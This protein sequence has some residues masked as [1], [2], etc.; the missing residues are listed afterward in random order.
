MLV[1]SARLQTL[2]EIA[3]ETDDLVEAAEVSHPIYLLVVSVLFIPLHCIS[4]WLR[5]RYSHRSIRSNEHPELKR[6]LPA[7]SDGIVASRKT[8]CNLM[9][10]GNLIIYFVMNVYVGSAVLLCLDALRW[11]VQDA[12]EAPKKVS[13]K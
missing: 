10:E 1:S 4:F 8:Y 7:Q 3:F 6:S 2:D 12:L 9:V 5:H 11:L 13:P